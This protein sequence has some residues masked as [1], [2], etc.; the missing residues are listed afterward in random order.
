MRME[1]ATHIPVSDKA[2]KTALKRP[3][4]FTPAFAELR[5]NE[6][7]PKR[8]VDRLFRGSG[9]DPAAPPQSIRTQRKT[10]AFRERAQG[11]DMRRRTGC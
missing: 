6:R 8:L 7:Q 1:D 10:L 9:N 5:L 3:L 2:R 11:L 4:E